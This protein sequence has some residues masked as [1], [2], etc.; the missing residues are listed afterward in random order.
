MDPRFIHPDLLTSNTYKP[1]DRSTFENSYQWT[2]RSLQ[3]QGDCVYANTSSRALTEEEKSA[4]MKRLNRMNMKLDEVDSSI[5]TIGGRVQ[6]LEYK[7]E[8]RNTSAAPSKVPQHSTHNT[9]HQK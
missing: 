1:G 5:Q 6:D 2:N 7:T 4:I 8:C 9:T 3:S